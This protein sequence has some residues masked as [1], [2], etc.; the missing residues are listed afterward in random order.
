[1]SHENQADF[2]HLGGPCLV[3]ATELLKNLIMEV[4]G[5]FTASTAA[6]VLVRGRRSKW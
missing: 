6:N 4:T 3:A 2:G 5:R 1:L